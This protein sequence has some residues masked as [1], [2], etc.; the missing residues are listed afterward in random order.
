VSLAFEPTPQAAA[1]RLAAVRKS[2]YARTR[3]H[4]DGAVTKLSP[5]LTHGFLHIPDAMRALNPPREHK[6][7]ESMNHKLVMEFGWREFFHHAWR[8]DGGAIFTS[9]HP[10]PLPDD[11]YARELPA[12]IREGRTGVP[13]IDQAVRA[14]YDTGYVHNHARMWL[15]SY[16]VHLRKVHWR[17]GADWLYAHLLDG[18]LASNHLSWQWVAG[19]GSHKPYLFN[20]ENVAR[21]APGEWHSE[22]TEIDR[23]YADLDRL[24]HASRAVGAQPGAHQGVAEPPLHVA[25][26][27][28][29][30]FTGPDQNAV[31]G[32]D[33]W[34]AHPWSLADAPPGT[35]VVAVLDA[36]FHR[37]WPWSERRWRFVATRL[38]SM[39]PHRWIAE[40]AALQATLATARSVRGIGNLHLGD[41]FRAFDLASMPRAFHD[42]PRR[43]RSFSAFWVKAQPVSTQ[44]DLFTST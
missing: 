13:A 40:P 33:V 11:A 12:D 34:L 8:H 39:T 41:T 2:D 14:L 26:P 44:P 1:Q 25:P 7:A 35:T 27:A 18:D 10:G 22:G 28:A 43:C 20:A 19:T 21:Y 32:R 30:G 38:A 5:Y 17:A 23:S 16:V 4:L 29:L 42:P 24:A 37:A 3:N 9:L 31:R 36:A 15:A 6:L